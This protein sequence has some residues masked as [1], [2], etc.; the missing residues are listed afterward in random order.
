MFVPVTLPPAAAAAL[1]A[2]VAKPS[3]QTATLARSLLGA[4]AVMGVVGVGFHACGV[5]PQHG[6]LGELDTE[7]FPGAAAIRAAELCRAGACGAGGAYA[8]WRETALMSRR[9]QGYDVLAKWNS[10]SWNDATR[11]VVADRLDK[12][13]R[14]RFFTE[15]EWELLNAICARLLPQPDREVPIPLVPWIDQ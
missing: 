13:P 6:R 5:R 3:P 2:A 14:R 12:V 9:Y 4:M 7:P 8:R 11:K 1:A 10:P 15:A